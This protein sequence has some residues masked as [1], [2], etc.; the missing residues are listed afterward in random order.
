MKLMRNA[1]IGLMVLVLA[2][3]SLW[4]SSCKMDEDTRIRI[5]NTVTIDD[6]SL[7]I[8][9]QD[10]SFNADTK[11]WM[12]NVFFMVYPKI[13]E[14]FNFQA[15]KKVVFIISRESK[16]AKAVTTD[17]AVTFNA[18]WLTQHPEDIDLV[19]RQLMLVVGNYKRESSPNWLVQ[20]MA[21]YG[22]YVFGVYN[23]EAGWTLPKVTA[24]QKYDQSGPITA[25]FLVWLERRI[26]QKSIG[27]ISEVLRS[28]TYSKAFW[29]ETTGRSIDQLW[30]LYEKD[31]AINTSF[32]P[33]VFAQAAD[34]AQIGLMD[35]FWN[36]K[37]HFFITNN[38]GDQG[39]NY[40]WNAHG[41]DVLIDAYLRTQQDTFKVAIDQIYHGIMSKNGNTFF[42]DFNDD[43]E[44]MAL[45]CLRAYDATHVNQYISTAEE[46][47]LRI[48]DSWS[49]IGGG[50]IPW[51]PSDPNGKNACS[52]GPAAILA[53]RL[54]RYSQNEMY[55]DWAKKI[56]EWE[57][58]TL[59]DPASGVVWDN[60]NFSGSE[61]GVV[62]DWTFT[63][64]QG[65][66]IGAA[67]ELFLLTEDSTYLRDA[68]KTAHYTM[69]AISFVNFNGI[70]TESGQGDGG[71]FKGIFSRYLNDLILSGVL[72]VSTQKQ[73]IDFL[74]KNGYS[75]LNRGSVSQGEGLILNS[76][77]SNPPDKG[78]TDA[79]SQISGV[80]LFE[81]LAELQR[82]GLVQ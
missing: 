32:P 6:Y 40:W 5:D 38:H 58:K 10:S 26:S 21:D 52:N 11:Q 78:Q 37:E 51:K 68:M 77:W 64:N 44:W 33:T 23:K 16:D 71:L 49:D 57:K 65:T 72:P 22:R 47:W 60:I 4:C 36:P 13:V 31:P 20:G 46:L 75:L 63:Y 43:M 29:K 1:Y 81:A 28:G 79:S 45:A 76:D 55:L 50:G 17:S 15:P 39:Y 66:Y 8:N 14:R 19:T 42:N 67:T 54:Y 9:N 69:T 25:R 53:A 61:E 24:E 2:V 18:A 27:Q 73:Y 56:Y 34:K 12:S 48:I 35:D 62:Q 74:S 80:M 70:L 82:N 3:T 7:T 30:Q 41:L 59:V